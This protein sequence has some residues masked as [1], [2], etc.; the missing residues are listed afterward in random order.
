MSENPRNPQGGQDARAVERLAADLGCI[1][2]D[3]EQ[4]LRDIDDC[5]Q[6]IR[7]TIPESSYSD[8]DPEP[9]DEMTGPMPVEPPKPR[10]I[11]LS[12][13]FDP[14]Q[15]RTRLYAHSDV[16]DVALTHEPGTT[17]HTCDIRAHGREFHGTGS[18]YGLAASD[19][20][21]RLRAWRDACDER[22]DVTFEDEEGGEA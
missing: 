12:D 7:S 5:E 15:V 10:L 20:L 4:V 2:A 9:F 6:V 14:E 11:P 19:A 18:S 21:F 1:P 8:L 3:A 13:L 17:R 22:N 16:A